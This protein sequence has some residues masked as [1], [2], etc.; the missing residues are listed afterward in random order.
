MTRLW[1]VCGALVAMAAPVPSPAA[2]P[3]AAVTAR[4]AHP[5]EQG[6]AILALFRGA[7]APHPAAALAAWRRATGKHLSKGAE[8]LIAVLNPAMIA[9][10]KTLDGATFVLSPEPDTGRAC[11][12][13]AVPHD[14]GTF[15]ALAT[16]LV[17][18]DG[19]G[20]AP[21]G[22]VPVDRL[23]PP[24]APLMAR[25]GERVVLAG[26][27]GD[28][29][30]ALA[31]APAAA[32]AGAAPGLYLALDPSALGTAGPLA[33]RRAAEAL[34]ALG[35]R[36]ARVHAA[37]ERDALTLNVT[38]RFTEPV[39]GP[40]VQPRWLDW[41]PAG[42]T[43]AVAAWGVDRRPEAWDRAFALADRVERADPARAGV[44]P[45]RTRLNL[46]AA[47][48]KVRPEVDLWPVLAGITACA[49]AERGDVTGAL[50]AL[51]AT[52]EAAAARLADTVLPRLLA[53]RS[54]PPAAAKSATTGRALGRLGGRPVSVAR[55]GTTVVL[56]W[57]ETALAQGLDAFENPER[58]AGPLVRATWAGTAP[59][60]AGAF[61]PGR[62]KALGGTAFAA[63]NAPPVLWWGRDEGRATHDVIRWAGL[64][65]LVRRLLDGLPLDPPPDR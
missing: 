59:P 11:W 55:R 27:R 29:Q 41:A 6:A 22:A 30:S 15:A 9:E 14:D 17:L 26:A 7:R 36:D 51:H 5:D 33:Q 24:G 46:L 25:Q 16:A 39:N 62:L 18:T 49:L 13:A 65:G 58:S 23:G 50:V 45:L 20:D 54:E 64:D 2:E 48:A 8:A 12:S 31:R 37:F 19:A 61:W 21:V 3:A 32:P 44:A 28:L 53:A 34:R 60:R 52:D 43:L 56:G 4:I 57:G 38:S 10:L 1:I 40:G 47:A 63:A 42:A 35:C